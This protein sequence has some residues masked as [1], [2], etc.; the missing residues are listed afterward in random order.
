MEKK[1]YKSEFKVIISQKCVSSPKI[2]NLHCTAYANSYFKHQQLIKK[3]ATLIQ[4]TGWN[5]IC[6]PQ[7]YHWFSWIQTFARV[8][9]LLPVGISAGSRWAWLVP[10]AVR[11][12][13]MC[14]E[15]PRQRLQGFSRQVALGVSTESCEVALHCRIFCRHAVLQPSALL[16]GGRVLCWHKLT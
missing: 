16:A 1:R 5:S 8:V 2:Q 7:F 15:E 13:S 14:E 3:T 11:S 12:H 10:F 4:S 9:S 6:S